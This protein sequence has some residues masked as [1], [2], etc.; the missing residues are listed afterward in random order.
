MSQQ[1]ISGW[2]SILSCI[3]ALAFAGAAS[4][5]NPAGLYYQDQTNAPYTNIASF[6]AP[7]ALLVTGRCNRTNPHFAQAR[8]AGAEVLAYIDPVDILQTPARCA[9]E[10]FIGMLFQRWLRQVL[11]VS[12]PPPSE[13][14]IRARAE[15]VVARFWAAY[16]RGPH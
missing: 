7:T 11:Y 5:A 4:A 9:A 13:A 14:S 16:R 1:R 8:A 3:G 6:Y 10:F 2:I 12:Q 15:R